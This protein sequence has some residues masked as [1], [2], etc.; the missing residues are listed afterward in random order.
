MGFPFAQ[1]YKLSRNPFLWMGAFTLIAWWIT[2]IYF[3]DVWFA[4]FSSKLLFKVCVQAQL[5]DVRQRKMISF[6]MLRSL[7]LLLNMNFL[8]RA[9]AV[10]HSNIRALRTRL[11]SASLCVH[12]FSFQFWTFFFFIFRFLHSSF[13]PPHTTQCSCSNSNVLR[14]SFLV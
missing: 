1:T 9:V 14:C 12:A 4:Y 10:V 3:I 6:H 11:S 2:P 8:L 7:F 13:S 5:L